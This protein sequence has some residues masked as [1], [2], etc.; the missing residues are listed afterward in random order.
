[1]RA[2]SR[3]SR[4]RAEGGRKL[5]R[6]LG[7]ELRL[8]HLVGAVR[9]QRGGLRPRRRRCRQGGRLA[10]RHPEC[11]RRLGRGLRQLQARL[12]RLRA[13]ADHGLADGLGAAGADGRGRGRSP[14]RGAR[15]RLSAADPGRDRP[16]AA[17]RL[18]RRRFPARLL[19]ALSRLSA[20]FS[21]SGP[22]RAIAT[23]SAAIRG[24]SRTVC[25]DPCR[26]RPAARTA[27]CRRPRRRGR[28]R[29]RRS[30]AAGSGA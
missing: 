22:W 20:I 25:D 2:A 28:R 13:G 10:G 23:S 3:L 12:S 18:Y 17:G 24:A 15:H 26:H 16:V 5:V 7:R 27:H 11:G 21:R 14:R 29:W 8:W 4:A 6:P 19:P 1:M 9:A 30:C